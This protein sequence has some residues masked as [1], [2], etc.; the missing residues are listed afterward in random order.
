MTLVK[1]MGLSLP[2]GFKE[3]EFE[4]GVKG[5]FLN[6]GENRMT[7]ERAMAIGKGLLR[8]VEGLPG[9]KEALD[10]KDWL[11]T[12]VAGGDKKP[13]FWLIP[14]YTSERM[15]AFLGAPTPKA[16]EKT[17]CGCPMCRLE[18]AVAKAIE[19]EARAMLTR[20]EIPT[21]LQDQI[22]EIVDL[23]QFASN[24]KEGMQIAIMSM[25]G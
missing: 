2:A 6:L 23:A 18:L 4:P 14:D 11:S 9:N 10:A 22:I 17:E 25:R 19:Y 5:V 20:E 13:E 24:F 8:L 16:E 1:L 21:E 12:I 15:Q 3:G 7:E